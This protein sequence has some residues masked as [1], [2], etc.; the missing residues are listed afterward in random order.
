MDIIFSLVHRDFGG[1]THDLISNATQ[2]HE[3]NHEILIGFRF[4]NLEISM[5]F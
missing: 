4:R 1:Q 5:A 2:P 3:M